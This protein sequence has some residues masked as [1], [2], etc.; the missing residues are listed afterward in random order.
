MMRFTRKGAISGIVLP[1]ALA[2]ALS[3]GVGPGTARSAEMGKSTVYK[4]PTSGTIIDVIYAAEF[5]E[6]W[7]KCREKNGIAVYSYDRTRGSW[8]KALFE[9][10]KA[11]VEKAAKE[12]PAD[13]G[14]VS[15]EKGRDVGDAVKSGEKKKSGEKDGS[16]ESA[17]KTEPER[18]DVP[19]P[20]KSP[21]AQP[22]K[23]K[24]WNPMKLFQKKKSQPPE[25]PS[26][27][28]DRKSK[29]AESGG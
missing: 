26:K 15:E 4:V 11:S 17:G 14:K 23:K 10:G 18:V 1:A 25:A 8:A 29:P 9:P 13:A 21:A 22:D 7:V 16:P 12:P 3:L 5:D 19:P 28:D 27:G 24:W 20:K 2:V 6:W